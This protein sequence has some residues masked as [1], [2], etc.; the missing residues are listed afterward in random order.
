MDFKDAVAAD[1]E[2]VFFKT[3]EFAEE[4]IIDGRPVPFILDNDALNGKSD[5]YAMGLAYGEQLIFI[6]QK[7]LFILPKEGDQMTIN[8]KQ[9]YV[10]HAYNNMG[11]FEIRIGRDLVYD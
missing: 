6:K 9:W 1:V 4:A 8:D 5:V 7:D 10:K 11:V 2:N 3:D